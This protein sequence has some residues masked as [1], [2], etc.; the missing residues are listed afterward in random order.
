MLEVLQ[1]KRIVLQQ[2]PQQRRPFFFCTRLAHRR[3]AYT[4]ARS[5][6]KDFEANEVEAGS[7]CLLAALPG[8]AA[9]P[10]ETGLPARCKVRAV[11]PLPRGSRGSFVRGEAVRHLENH[12]FMACFM[13]FRDPA[14]FLVRGWSRP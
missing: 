11:R 7:N 4:K 5:P 14:T 9:V 3:E 6:G 1:H 8:V 13:A 10:K 2:S 12:L